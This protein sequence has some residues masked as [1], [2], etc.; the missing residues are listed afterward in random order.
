MSSHLD[1]KQVEA[2]SDAKK[3]IL[4]FERY[5]MDIIRHK[6]QIMNEINQNDDELS[7][8]QL[9]TLE[10]ITIQ[11]S[12][13][14]EHANYNAAFLYGVIIRQLIHYITIKNFQRLK[15][16][17]FDLITDISRALYLKSQEQFNEMKSDIFKYLNTKLF[18]IYSDDDI[19]K[20]YGVD[21]DSEEMN[22]PKI[23]EIDNTR[24]NQQSQFISV[25]DYTGKC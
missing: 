6:N 21:P 13:N 8:Q 15:K 4:K 19:M 10:Q 7:E 16:L 18:Y 9:H 24:W 20:L 22:N 17:T 25:I 5:M 12:Y 14:H 3:A 2:I 1:S 11:H 23:T